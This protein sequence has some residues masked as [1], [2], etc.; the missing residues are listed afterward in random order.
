MPYVTK[1]R[2]Q[3]KGESRVWG[4]ILTRVLKRPLVSTL[5]AG[6]LLVALCIPALGIQFKEPGLRRLLAQPAGHP[7]LR[8][9]SRPP[10]PA[11]PS[12]PRP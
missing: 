9:A 4:A 6:G 5:L 12:R 2:H 11:A 1:R 7:D 3:S 10:S 8:P